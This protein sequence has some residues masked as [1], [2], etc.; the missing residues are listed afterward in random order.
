MP[1]ATISNRAATI[2]APK[3]ATPIERLIEDG[4]KIADAL[5]GNESSLYILA[6]L[7]YASAGKLNLAIEAAETAQFALIAF[8][9]LRKRVSVEL[10]QFV[11]DLKRDF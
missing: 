6:A 1:T 3:T 5:E 7:E 8:P 4:S 9:R 10:S 2:A 11:A